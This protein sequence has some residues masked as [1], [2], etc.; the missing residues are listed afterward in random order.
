MF[1]AYNF[2]KFKGNEINF[3]RLVISISL[4]SLTV[5][6]TGLQFIFPEIIG[7]LDRT[8]EALLAGE[9]WRLITPLFIQP[10]GIWQCVFNGIFFLSFVPIA[11]HLYGRSVILI[12]F[13]TGLV[14]QIVNFYWDRPGSV[15]STAKGGSSTAIYGIM[16]SLFMF[17]LLNQKIFPRGYVLLPLAGFLGASILC[18]FRDGH[19]PSLLAGGMLSLIIH[20]SGRV[21]QITAY[22][23]L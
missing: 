22:S 14:G 17:I 5:I 13:G 4:L 3:T 8:K 20:Q 19:A 7:A 6:V 11:E 16:G 18:F 23:Q 2:Y 15:L 9:A 1:F 12:Y 10:M 21:R